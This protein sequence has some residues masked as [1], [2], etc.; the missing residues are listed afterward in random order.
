MVITRFLL[1]S[2]NMDAILAE[3]TIYKMLYP[4]DRINPA[5]HH[6]RGLRKRSLGSY[7]VTV[8]VGRYQPGH[9]GYSI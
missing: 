4:I 7:E 5:G 6:S 2:L 3:A 1:V 9:S 8:G